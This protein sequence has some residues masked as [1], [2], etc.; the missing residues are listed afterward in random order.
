MTVHR[1]P[2]EPPPYAGHVIAMVDRLR[3]AGFE[4]AGV[5]VPA[6]PP[7][8]AVRVVHTLYG[9]PVRWQPDD[10]YAVQVVLDVVPDAH[11]GDHD[12]RGR[13]KLLE[14]VRELPDETIPLA[15]DLF[16]GVFV[17][18]VGARP[19]DAGPAVAEAFDHAEQWRA[20]LTWTC[21]VCGAERPDDK[22]SVASATFPVA[23]GRAEGTVNRRYCNDRTE[24]K[25]A[26]PIAARQEAWRIGGAGA[27][28]G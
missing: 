21:H 3:A 8:D 11:L 24:C 9:L 14:L 15:L 6:P 19:A 25:A 2:G 23:G 26:A 17:A 16:R 18:A 4:P 27:D 5:L 28:R 20:N 13:D 1:R 22:I 10:A 12:A 7:E